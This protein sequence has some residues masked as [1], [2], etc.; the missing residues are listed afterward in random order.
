M[1]PRVLR[2]T[3]PQDFSWIYRTGKRIVSPHLRIFYA[4][5]NQNSS[6]FGFVI[7]KKQVRKIV[8]R[9]R[10][11]RILRSQIRT[12]LPQLVSGLLVVIQVRPEILQQKSPEIRSE[13]TGILKKARL[14]KK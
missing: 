12:I 2:L 11:K 13:L 3:K 8:A 6:R 14:L 4:L 5:T 1:L 10:L 9:N 7:S